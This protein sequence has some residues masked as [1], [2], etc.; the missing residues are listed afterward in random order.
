MTRQQGIIR[1]TLQ[2]H[3]TECRSRAPHFSLT[4]ESDP[5]VSLRRRRP[6]GSHAAAVALRRR[7]YLPRTATFHISSL[8]G[9]PLIRKDLSCD[10]LPEDG[11]RTL[12]KLNFLTMS[13]KTSEVKWGFLHVAQ[14]VMHST[15]NR[16]EEA[17]PPAGREREVERPQGVLLH[18]RRRRHCTHYVLQ[19]TV[20][21][22]QT[23]DILQTE[24]TESALGLTQG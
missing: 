11:V 12:M 5:R 9:A 10:I 8:Q 1:Y 3:E 23:W 19:G 20:F 13:H 7:L 21:T 17:M 24:Y 22:G 4:F 6:L 15:L 14:S 16:D 2:I 18:L